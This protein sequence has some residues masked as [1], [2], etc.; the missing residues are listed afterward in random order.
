[1]RSFFI[2]EAHFAA[3]WME[4]STQVLFTFTPEPLPRPIE[5]MQVNWPQ[6]SSSKRNVWTSSQTPKSAESGSRRFGHGTV[7]WLVSRPKDQSG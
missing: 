7:K 6:F 4:K 5:A 1:M 3:G 2:P